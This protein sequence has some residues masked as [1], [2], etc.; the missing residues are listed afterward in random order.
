MDL[1]KITAKYS[2]IAQVITGMIDIIALQVKSN[3]L[4]LRQLLGLELAVQLIEFVFYVWLVYKFPSH[5]KEEITKYRYY[6]WALSTNIMLFTL[7]VYIVHLQYPNKTITEIYKENKANIHLVLVLNT[8]MLILG[9]LGE[10]KKISINQSVY[11]GFIPFFIYY[12]IIYKSYVKNDVLISDEK[13]REINFLFW[14]FVLVWGTYGISALFPYTQ[15]NVSY[16]ILDV[17]SKNFFGL[18]LSWKVFKD[19]I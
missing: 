5:S 15:K 6:D 14:Y 10:I 3:V 12:G 18:Y 19:R 7:I 1:V 2:L 8:L 11:L 4:I 13:K 17:F 9:Y 16:N